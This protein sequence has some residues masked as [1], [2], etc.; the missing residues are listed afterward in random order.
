[1]PL[2][3]GARLGPYEILSGL[4]ADGMGEVY[5]VVDTRLN[6]DVAIKILPAQLAEDPVFRERFDR[7]ALAISQLDHPHICAL[8]DVGVQDGHAAAL[9]AGRQGAD[10]RDDDGRVMAVP[11][12]ETAGGIEVGNPTQLFDTRLAVRVAA[13]PPYSSYAMTPDAQRFD[14]L[15]PTDEGD[16]SDRI[17]VVLNWPSLLSR[18]E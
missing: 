7:E 12:A 2:S 5:R 10:L 17:H 9:E 3:T 4:G 14:V 15:A 18:R 16:T 6:R 13:G 1:M 8:Y 11:I